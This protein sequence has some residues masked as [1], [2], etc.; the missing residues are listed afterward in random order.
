MQLHRLADNVGHLVESAVIHIGESLQYPPLYRFQT[1]INSGDG[2]VTDVVG[3]VFDE[4][5]IEKSA[6]FTLFFRHL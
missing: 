2:T 5:M 6:E 3:C 4:I 1:I